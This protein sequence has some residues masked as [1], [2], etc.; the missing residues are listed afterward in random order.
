MEPWLE[1]QWKAAEQEVQTLLSSNGAMHTTKKSLPFRIREV[2]ALVLSMGER[3]PHA[4]SSK[5]PIPWVVDTNQLTVTCLN[6]VRNDI[7]LFDLE[8]QFDSD[9]S[10]AIPKGRAS[11]PLCDVCGNSDGLVL[12]V[13]GV[14]IT[15]IV[16]Q[17]CSNCQALF[18]D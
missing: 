4:S 12:S 6:C 8:Q 9:T 1:D 2:V 16:M 15:V 18:E 3:C 5:S 17:L 13:L 7:A 11:T 14:G 10:E